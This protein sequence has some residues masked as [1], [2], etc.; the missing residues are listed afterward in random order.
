M[1]ILRSKHSGW[2]WEH[3][4]TPFGG[5]G[6]DI[7]SSIGNAVSNVVSGIG[8]GVSDIAQG[9]IGQGLSELAPAA[10]GAGL[11]AFTGGASLALDAGAIAAADSVALSTYGVTAAEA[12]AS[13]G[14]PA[15]EL[16]LPAAA[17]AADIGA[18]AG[19]A[20]AEFA[21]TAAGQEALAATAQALSP[22]AAQSA[23]TLASQL[24]YSDPIAAIA[25]GVNPADLGMAQ[26]GAGGLGNIL[27][28]AKT[29]AQLI[30]G[31]SQLASANQT[32]QAGKTVSGLTADPY[33][34]YR[35]QAASQ[36]QNLLQNPSTITS[37]PGYQFNL[38][39]GLQAQQA[40]QAAQGRLVSGGGLLQAQQFGQQY[41]TSNLQQQESLLAQL[42]GATQ[43]PASGATAQ[44][45]LAFGGAGAGA[46]SLQQ[47]GAGAANVINPLQTLYSQY[48][49]PSPGV[50]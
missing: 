14:I 21:G 45:G 8:A 48:N 3:K 25:G 37:T 20:S 41:A 9:N 44:A 46:L 10:I 26:S 28:Y 43:A 1:S 32:R 4:R 19:T 12:M 34:Q 49:N 27:G 5:G 42:S 30:G 40:Q 15:A 16:G 33:A 2:T 39:Q 22:A 18:V 6:G 35:S 13:Y 31:V 47:Y 29:G 24:G 36:L 38:Q 50:Q 7:F 23:Q 11:A 17:T